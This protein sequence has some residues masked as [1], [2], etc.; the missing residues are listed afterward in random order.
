MGEGR[1]DAMRFACTIKQWPGGR[2][3]IQHTGSEIG[4]V[5]ATGDSREA[6]VEKMRGELRYRL[7]LCPC[8]GE[9]YQHIQI[10]VLERN[11]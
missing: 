3:L 11:A 2:W 8:S 5:D 1:S 7:E 6:A 10:E 4:T 9:S